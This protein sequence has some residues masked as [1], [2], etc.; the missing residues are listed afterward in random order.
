MMKQQY[1]FWLSNFLEHYYTRTQQKKTELVQSY[2]DPL[3]CNW[4]S[5]PKQIDMRGHTEQ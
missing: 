1:F 4:L 3:Q 2:S 5:L